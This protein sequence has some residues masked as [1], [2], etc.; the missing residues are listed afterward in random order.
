MGFVS[1]GKRLQEDHVFF[2]AA[3]TENARSQGTALAPIRFSSSAENDGQDD[4]GYYGVDD[5]GANE[6]GDSDS[7][8]DDKIEYDESEYASASS[9]N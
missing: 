8:D 5:M 7:S 4:D 6:A 2:K 9:R 1:Q 3:D